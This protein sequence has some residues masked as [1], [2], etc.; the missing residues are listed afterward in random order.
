MYSPERCLDKAMVFA[1]DTEW[2]DYSNRGRRGWHYTATHVPSSPQCHLQ[3]EWSPGLL[4]DAALKIRCF[5]QW[6][7]QAIRQTKGAPQRKI[8]CEKVRK[9]PMNFQPKGVIFLRM[10]ALVSRSQAGFEFKFRGFVCLF[11]SLFSWGRIFFFPV[12]SLVQN[13]FPSSVKFWESS[14]FGKMVPR[15]LRQSFCFLPNC[16]GKWP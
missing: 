8:N 6:Q 15:S 4:S 3:S 14:N 7:D 12:T 9:G 11:I 1:D 13:L 10:V 5:V 16:S 2:A